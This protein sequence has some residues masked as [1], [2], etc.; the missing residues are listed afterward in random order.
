M[1]RRFHVE[2]GVG[3]SQTALIAGSD[4]NHIRNVLRLGPGDP[5]RVFDGLGNEYA[6]R[7]TEMLKDRIAVELA[8]KFESTSES[9]IELTVSPALLKGS[10]MDELIRPLT[11]LGMTRWAPFKA[12]RSVPVLNDKKSAKRFERWRT[13]ASESMKQCGRWRVPDILPP[14][15]F[16]ELVEKADRRLLNII[17]HE[18]A[19]ESIHSFFKCAPESGQVGAHILI[20]PEGGFSGEEAELAIGNGFFPVSLG[21]RILRAETAVL[22][23][24]ALIQHLLGDL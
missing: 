12:S 24:S 10:K 20:G 7:I 9:P 11:E 17:F 5:I 16:K 4:V 21:P 19:A 3:G 18:N 15:E 8:E 6:A 2:T 1:T 14:V 13:I 23:A 22:T